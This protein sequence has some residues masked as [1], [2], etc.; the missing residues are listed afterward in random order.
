MQTQLTER[1]L[2][3]LNQVKRTDDNKWM[4]ACP[5]HDDHNPSLSI[6]CGSDG[7]V[8]VTCHAGCDT[9]DVLSAVG[10]SM[11]DLYPDGS[12]LVECNSTC[13]LQS[14]NPPME[15]GG[16]RKRVSTYDY[17]DEKGKLLYQVVRYMPK[18][19]RQRCPD[20]NG[21]WKWNMD[22][23]SRVLYRLPDI[24]SASPDEWIFITEGEKDA[25][26]LTGI[27]ATATTN[28]GGAGKWSK[29][30]DISVLEGRRVVII[31][32]CD[33]PGYRHG[34]DVASSLEG[35][36]SDVRIIDLR[37]I[38]E[39]EGNDV[40]DWLEWLECREPEEL[41]D[42]L[43][44]MAEEAP[45]YDPTDWLT[46]SPLS[47]SPEVQTAFPCE[48]LTPWLG[49]M[50]KEV[51]VSMQTPPALAGSVGLGIISLCFSGVV[52]VYPQ[53]D[54]K[55]PL[56]LYV[57]VAL[58]TG[59][60]KTPVYDM[61]KAPLLDWEKTE[62]DRL[63]PLITKRNA[64]LRILSKR[65]KKKENLAVREDDD[66][67]KE[68]VQIS[69]EIEDLTIPKYPVLFTSDVTAEATVRLLTEQGG[70]LGIMSSE[71]GEIKDIIMGR[72]TNNGKSNMEVFL[73][74]HSGDSIR[75]H[76]ASPDREPIILDNPVLNM[77]LCFQPTVLESIWESRELQ[78]RG[79]RARFLWSLPP[80]P[81]GHREQNPPGVSKS[82]KDL[83]HKTITTILDT[84]RT[85]D[86]FKTPH[87]LSLSTDAKAYLDEF[88]RELEPELGL[89][90]RYVSNGGWASKLPG[91]IVRIAGLIH[92]ANHV[93]EKEPWN[94]PI[95]ADTMNAA[96]RIGEYYQD[97]LD[98]IQ[99]EYCKTPEVQIEH[100][101]LKWI[102]R[103]EKSRFSTHDAYYSLGMKVDDIQAPLELLEA[104]NYIR[105]VTTDSGKRSGRKSSQEW[106]VN[107]E[108]LGDSVDSVG[109]VMEVS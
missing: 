20:G 5:A 50:V 81:L 8:L 70:R 37:V 108:L 39:L 98:Q 106:E 27:G 29:I 103:H 4:A 71:G 72:Y 64:D 87:Q 93:S 24:V 84:Y 33:E 79:L 40:S 66:V 15:G 74:G 77:V 78:D 60:R 28:S 48:V 31:P 25:D 99:G 67:W 68:A 89:G 80:N 30:D 7:R 91:A 92:L 83:Y 96:I 88:R 21:G 54:W 101:I 51:S 2:E 36:A 16:S 41:R 44:S 26:A 56:N 90:G 14:H 65:L 38:K 95:N 32:D 105:K 35:I 49:D 47:P 63:K 13:G 43:C 52:E 61:M 97:Q 19:F 3:R 82:V 11:E 62:R 42:S 104:Q 23:V 10:L 76:R 9:V 12:Y 102:K 86:P 85:T 55:E 45:E 109:S 100:R 22:G 1:L 53:S 69:H 107:P 46:P 58:P 73:K 75:V 17:T 94:R 6:G 59:C 18:D 34:Q 57:S